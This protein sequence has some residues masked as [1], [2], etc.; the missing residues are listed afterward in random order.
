ML[1]ALASVKI[2]PFNSPMALKS[3]MWGRLETGSDEAPVFGTGVFF[4]MGGIV[5]AH[6]WGRSALP[7]SSVAIDWTNI[8]LSRNSNRVDVDC[9]TPKNRCCRNRWLAAER[10][11]AR[12]KSR[13]YCSL[14]NAPK[15]C[16][17]L[18]ENV[19]RQSARR[20]R[21]RCSLALES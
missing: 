19:F 9:V 14:G 16:R 2:P 12:E 18:L 20:R 8:A 7:S 21:C 15:A 3:H 17:G 13:R 5:N 10:L 4:R 6:P 11:A 1:H